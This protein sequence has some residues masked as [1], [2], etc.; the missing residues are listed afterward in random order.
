MTRQQKI[1]K[2]KR[3]GFRVAIVPSGKYIATKFT[4]TFEAESINAL[5]KQIYGY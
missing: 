1:D 2:M 5:H 4:H 3:A